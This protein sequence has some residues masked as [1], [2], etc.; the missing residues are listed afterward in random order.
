M[1]A[2]QPI[3]GGTDRFQFN[4]R[5]RSILAYFYGKQWDPLIAIKRG[6]Q[7]GGVSQIPIAIAKY[8][9]G[10]EIGLSTDDGFQG[11]IQVG[12]FHLERAAFFDAF[13]GA[14][15]SIDQD[16]GM[17]LQ[18]KDDL[19]GDLLVH[20]FSSCH[21][22]IGLNYI[23]G[24]HARRKIAEHHH[25]GLFSPIDHLNPLG[26]EQGQEQHEHDQPPESL[27]AQ[28]PSR[29]PVLNPDAP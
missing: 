11:R 24:G 15:E 7:C 6:C 27:Q 26:P 21:H 9:Y 10:L 13:G 12:A 23:S 28:Y 16:S 25:S 19:I 14:S 8:Q 2:Q 17:G 22:S 4:I 1:F 3:R 29:P 5:Q 20:P 18:G